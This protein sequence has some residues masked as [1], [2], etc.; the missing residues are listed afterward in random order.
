MPK[1]ISGA[2]PDFKIMSVQGTKHGLE[3]A[4]EG[5]PLPQLGNLTKTDLKKI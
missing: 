3:E 2:L 5:V 4:C 1:T